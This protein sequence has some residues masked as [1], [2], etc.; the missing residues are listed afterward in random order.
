MRH[1][2]HDADGIFYLKRGCKTEK[3]Y[4]PHYAVQCF[5][6]KPFWMFLREF[7]LM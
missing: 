1:Q 6:E 2:C 3:T 5:V 4:A 7:L